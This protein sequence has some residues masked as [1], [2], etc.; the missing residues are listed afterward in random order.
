MDFGGF[1]VELGLIVA[2]V[3]CVV[4]LVVKFVRKSK[5]TKPWLGLTVLSLALTAI[6]GAYL[7]QVYGLDEPMMDAAQSGDGDKVE[8]LLNE[9]ANP[10]AVDE[11]GMSAI[12]LAKKGEHTLIV[13]LLRRYG[14]R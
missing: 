2:S 10:N 7:R 5:F 4:V 12:E 3:V 8:H 13:Q 9:G 11:D 6:G 14:A 1:F